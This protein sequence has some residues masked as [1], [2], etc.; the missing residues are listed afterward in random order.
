M[1]ILVFLIVSLFA[2]SEREASAQRRDSLINGAVVGAA[3][4]AGAGIAFTHAVRDSDLTA[5]QYARGAVIF[6]AIG[7]GIGLG[8]DALLR[9]QSHAPA[10]PPRI[11]IRP[12]VWR[13][14]T[15]VNLILRW[16]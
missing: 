10:R 7:A 5:S 13:G 15:K 6:G 14:M 11:V 1:K 8:V 12:I 2:L 16:L 4:G 9:T 3:I